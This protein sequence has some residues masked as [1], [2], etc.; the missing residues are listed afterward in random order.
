MDSHVWR[1]KAD[2]HGWRGKVKSRGVKQKMVDG[3]EQQWK[4][5]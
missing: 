4:K 1:T 2:G 5:D 3:E